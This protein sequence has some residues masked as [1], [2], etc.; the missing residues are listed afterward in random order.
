MSDD[1]NNTGKSKSNRFTEMDS[2]SKSELSLHS[3]P[4]YGEKTKPSSFTLYP[5]DKQNLV[6]I[7]NE[8]KKFSTKKLTDSQTVRI[9]IQ[10]LSENL[11]NKD[12]DLMKR[13]QGLVDS[14]R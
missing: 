7:N 11:G 12:R 3:T 10:Y 4:S 2:E 1:K 5:K 13:I 9:A 8:L 6:K 14:N